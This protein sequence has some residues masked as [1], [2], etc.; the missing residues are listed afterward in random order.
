MALG[1]AS[2]VMLAIYAPHRPG[3]LLG[4]AGI[5][6]LLM[7]IHLGIGDLLPWLLRW[8]GFAVPPLFDRPWAARSL[9]DFWGRRWNLA[10]VD[11]NRR[12][13]LQP[14]YGLFGRRGSRLMLF[15]RRVCCTN[16]P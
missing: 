11:M 4:L 10:F 9:G 7:T 5:A 13:L 15:A 8:A 3:G 2:I 14:M 16:W 6:A 1:A 12:M